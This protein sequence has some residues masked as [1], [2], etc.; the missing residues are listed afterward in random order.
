MRRGGLRRIRQIAG[1]NCESGDEEPRMAATTHPKA[2]ISYSWGSNERSHTSGMPF[3]GVMQADF[4]LYFFNALTSYKEKTQQGFI[5]E[6]LVYYREHAA[7]FEIFAR[8]ESLR[9]FQKLCPLLAV[10]SKGELGEALKLFGYQNA[11]IYLPRWDAFHS[12]SLEQATN[13]QKL[14]TK[15]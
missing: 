12:F 11:P 9:Y 5:P 10:K 3:S 15:S 1:A 14:A 7:P 6:T 2:F 8:S 4:V 13:F